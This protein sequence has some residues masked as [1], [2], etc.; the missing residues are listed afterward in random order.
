LKDNLKNRNFCY[1]AVDDGEM[2]V[3]GP[4]LDA[5]VVV[6]PYQSEVHETRL[7]GRSLGAMAASRSPEYLFVANT[8][9]GNVTVMDVITGK[10]VATVAVG[11]APGQIVVTDDDL[12]AITVNSQSGD[13]AVL[14][15][16]AFGRTRKPPAQPPL[17]TMIPVGAKPVSAVIRRA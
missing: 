17:L 7:V 6:Y 5:L 14:D 2:Y 10:M 12:Y 13:M 4:G 16:S 3:T 1:K 11:A 9:S 8:E 15:I